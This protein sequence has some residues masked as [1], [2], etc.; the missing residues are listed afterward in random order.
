MQPKVLL[1]FFVACSHCWLM[2][3][4]VSTRTGQGLFCRVVYQLVSPQPILVLGVIPS[5]VQDSALPIV[6]LHEHPVGPF[7]QPAKVPLNSSSHTH[8]VH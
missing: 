7:L 5:Q 2:S 8:V 3:N 4:K 6:D 1:V